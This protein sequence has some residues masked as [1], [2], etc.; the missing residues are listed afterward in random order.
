MNFFQAII[1]KLPQYSPFE[2][3]GK[4]KCVYCGKW[5]NEKLGSCCSEKK[6]LK[7]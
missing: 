4:V 5:Y 7:K 3:T 2:I 1:K 6:D